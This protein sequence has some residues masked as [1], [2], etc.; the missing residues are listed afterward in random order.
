[1][2]VGGAGTMGLSLQLVSLARTVKMKS[3]WL[4]PLSA[5][6]QFAAVETFPDISVSFGFS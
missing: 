1:M 2:C 6:A 5:V 4:S 3:S